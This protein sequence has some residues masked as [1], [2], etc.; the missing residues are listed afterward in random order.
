[1]L[2]FL[3]VILMLV[4]LFKLTGF[5]LGLFGRV[6]G[7]ILGFFGYLLLAVLAVSLL[8]IGIFILP[9]ILIAGVISIAA[10]GR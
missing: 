6:L 10:G 4:V 3:F 8:G 9:I 1:M 7:G 2:G 5:V